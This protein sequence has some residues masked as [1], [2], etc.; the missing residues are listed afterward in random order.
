MSLLPPLPPPLSLRPARLRGA[1]LLS[2]PRALSATYRRQW[3]R[4]RARSLEHEQGEGV[5][6]V[7]V[8]VC[9]CGWVG[10]GGGGA[11]TAG[12]IKQ[13]GELMVGEDAHVYCCYIRRGCDAKLLRSSDMTQHMW[14]MFL[15]M[16]A[17][18]CVQLL[19]GLIL[20]HVQQQV[21]REPEEE[22]EGVAE[23]RENLSE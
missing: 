8:C 14:I 2:L 12:E 16:A 18:G 6:E 22:G 23:R 4:E 3:A 7:C 21:D 19:S 13:N 11:E 1:L 10:G 17:A 9:V 15:H 5:E 20:Q